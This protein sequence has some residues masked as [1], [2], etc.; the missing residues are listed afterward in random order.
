M[1]FFFFLNLSARYNNWHK[2]STLNK[3]VYLDWI[4]CVFELLEPFSTWEKV[5]VWTS[6]KL[7][8]SHQAW[9]FCFFLR[10]TEFCWALLSWLQEPL[11]PAWVEKLEWETGTRTVGLLLIFSLPPTGLPF[12]RKQSLC[13]LQVV[14]GRFINPWRLGIALLGEVRRAA[15]CLSVC[16]R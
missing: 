1:W 3:Q 5:R 10:S 7:L 11:P 13:A 15:L 4:S 2:A 9:V 16:A 8:L 14:I 6:R 12:F